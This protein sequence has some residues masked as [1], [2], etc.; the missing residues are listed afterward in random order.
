MFTIG[1][2]RTSCEHNDKRIISLK[3]LVTRME[4]GNQWLLVTY[5]NNGTLEW[6]I[7]RNRGHL[8]QMG[9]VCRN[10]E[11]SFH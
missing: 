7:W 10:L 6:I 1:M 4:Y 5:G 2:L 11:T 3:G 9:S 8:V